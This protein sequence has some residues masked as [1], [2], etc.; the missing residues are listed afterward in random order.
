MSED[1][2][3]VSVILPMIDV[4]RAEILMKGVVSKL[5]FCLV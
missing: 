2:P 5:G 4:A 1:R 3:A